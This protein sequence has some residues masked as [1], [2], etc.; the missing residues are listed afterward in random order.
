M[1]TINKTET[2]NNVQ[3]DSVLNVGDSLYTFKAYDSQLAIPAKEGERVVKCLY[4]TNLKTGKIAGEN[5]YIVVPEKHLDESVVIENAAMLAPYISA[6]LQSV[7]DGIIKEHHKNGG[8]G[9][10]D[11][12]LS[13]AKILESLDDAG[14]GNR[15]NKEKIET[16]FNAEMKDSLLVAFADKMGVGEVPTE[17]ELAKLEQVT[18]VYKAKFESLASGKTH[19]RKEEAEL[20]QKA[21]E[22]TEV[23]DTNIGARF[24]GRL[25]K[26]KEATSND[27]LMSL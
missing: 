1:D 20:M 6:Y 11:S 23:L 24:Y 12:F 2:N 15:L 21:L 13:L 10:S 8:K 17:S 4:K 27:L 14:Q 22:V 7:E 3:A 5:S 18:S 19:Y 25:E 26:M 9:F 16:W